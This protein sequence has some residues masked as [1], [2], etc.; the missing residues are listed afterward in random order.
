MTTAC[1]VVLRCKDP[2]G[3]GKERTCRYYEA[4]APP[5]GPNGDGYMEDGSWHY[6]DLT[7]KHVEG[8]IG[9]CTHAR[10]RQEALRA[11]VREA[12]GVPDLGVPYRGPTE[13][14]ARTLLYT[15][16]YGRKVDCP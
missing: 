15:A 7:C 11:M 8:P 2:G 5:Q 13:E 12:L 3:W 14:E 10:M 9:G 6:W 1:E 16:P 4:V